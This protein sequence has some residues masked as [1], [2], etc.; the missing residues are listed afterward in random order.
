VSITGRDNYIVEKA[1]AYAIVM[2]DNLPEGKQELSDRMGMMK[3]LLELVPSERSR[4]NLM[5]VVERHTGLRPK[6]PRF[7]TDA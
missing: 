4:N 2:I 6:P 5:A 1:L 3:L 7:F